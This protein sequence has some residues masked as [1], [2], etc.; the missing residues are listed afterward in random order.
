MII[1]SNMYLKYKIYTH[2]IS[3]YK[4]NVSE[5]NERSKSTHMYRYRL[6][7]PFLKVGRTDCKY[8]GG[9]P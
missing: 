1:N 9:F 7:S 6:R 4:Y 3:V 5:L 8:I 2:V